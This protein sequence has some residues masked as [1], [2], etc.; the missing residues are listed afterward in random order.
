MAY[1]KW[2]GVDLTGTTREGKAFARSQQDLDTLLF[3]QEIA[4]IGCEPVR[5]HLFTPAINFDEK[6]H[7]FRQLAA[8]LDAGVMLPDALEILCDLMTNIRLQEV[9][10]DMSADIQGGVSLSDAL[11]KHPEVFDSLMVRM[12]RVGQET[13][14]LGAALDHLSTYLEVMNGFRK[15]LKSA[16]MLPMITFGFFA[17]IT[18]VIFVVIVPRFSD[19]FK[20]MNKELPAVTKFVVAISN[21]LRSGWVVLVLVLIVLA[22]FGI[23][24][25]TKSAHGKMIADRYMLHV[26]WF[27]QLTKNSSLTYFLHSVSMLLNNGVLLVKALQVSGAEIKN[28]V[29][30]AQ[31]Q[32]LEEAVT[33]GVALSQAMSRI[34]ESLFEQDL[35]SIARIGE[36]SGNLGEMLR[37][38]AVIYQDKVNRSI[39][40]FTTIFQPLLMII[41]GLMIT[42]LIF[43]IYLPV[44]NLANVV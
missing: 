13:G 10:Y 22:V 3:K 18:T 1:F 32:E 31:A 9:V 43:A 16:A 23:R 28:G 11:V 36:E 27:G 25:Y 39:T 30:H 42:M 20:S 44:F 15:R 41:L 34:P 33:S 6:I 37:K 14:R 24:Q 40:F 2:H 17:L 38:A 19:I 21:M 26:P 29:V 35:V 4:L 12:V 8:L 7:F 5:P